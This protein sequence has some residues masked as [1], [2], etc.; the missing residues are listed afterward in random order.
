WLGYINHNEHNVDIPLGADNKFFS[1]GPSTVAENLGQPSK[2]RVGNHSNVFYIRLA[3]ETVAMIWRLAYTLSNSAFRLPISTNYPVKCTGEEIAE[4][5]LMLQNNQ[6]IQGSCQCYH[7]YWGSNCRHPCPGGG[8]NPCYGNGVCESTN[9]T[10]TCSTRFVDT[11]DCRQCSEGWIGQDCSV[12]VTDLSSAAVGIHVGNVFSNSHFTTF[13]GCGFDFHGAGEYLLYHHQAEDIT[14]HVHA[15]P[16][17]Q[18]SLSSC[19]NAVAI[20]VS[21]ETLVIHGSFSPADVGGV[22]WHNGQVTS[23]GDQVILSTG[24]TIDRP[25]IDHYVIQS[26]AGFYLQVS[27]N[28]LYI[29]MYLQVTTPYCS[30]TTGLLSSCDDNAHNDFLTSGGV[31]LTNRT[32][33]QDTIHNNYGPSWFIHSDNTLFVYGHGNSDEQRNI[34]GNSR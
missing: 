28:V 13:D 30:A 16:C 8:H 12:S 10:C 27:V 24:Y 6:T 15:V 3:D 34:T 4:D 14:I 9:G 33:S 31:L 5:E 20:Q 29:D 11:P 21:T 17:S 26:S 23:I 22:V 7:G 18:D 32:L 2:F 19:I 1:M 25:S